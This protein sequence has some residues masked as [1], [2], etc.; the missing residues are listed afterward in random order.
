MLQTR[1]V[2]FDRMESY[3]FIGYDS[4]DDFNEEDLTDHFVEKGFDES[5]SNLLSKYLIQ[6]IGMPTV[7]ITDIVDYLR[8][9]VG[10]YNLIENEAEE[11]K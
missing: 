9:I 11:S 3:V 6:E 1:Q 10:P 5:E 4:S 2:A 8:K 7:N